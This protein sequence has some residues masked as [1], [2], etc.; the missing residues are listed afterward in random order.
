ME[1][2][3]PIDTGINQHKNVTDRR[4]AAEVLRK[5]VKGILD[6][7]FNPF[8]ENDSI[9][10]EENL[11]KMNAGDA[12]D[13]ALTIGKNLWAETSYPDLKS[14]V[15]QFK[16][17]LNDNG[18][19]NRYITAVTKKTVQRY[20]NTILA[21]SS[22][23]N[24]NNTK[25]TLSSAF[26][27]LVDNYIIPSNFIKEIKQLNS[28]PTRHRSYS[29]S[30]ETELYNYMLHND[31]LLLLYI[32]FVCYNFMRPVEVNRLRVKDLDIRDKTLIFQAK[33]K[34]LQTKYM[35]AILYKE[36]YELPLGEPED[37]IFTPT[38]IGKWDANE[39]SRREH[40]SKRFKLVKDVFGLGEDYGIYSFRHTFIT[41]LYNALITKRT[42]DDAMNHM[43]TITGHATQ[44]AL[45][46]YLRTTDTFKPEDWS[47][48]LE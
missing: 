47:E 15:T 29:Q 38:G 26:T 20:L 44:S 5:T 14:R 28:N 4:A 2:Q 45:K 11:E 6:A 42:P 40:F 35:P 19:K 10:D 23:S 31:R 22:A 46:K 41:K 3:T 43:L 32:K 8:L 13:Y 16:I 18:Y 48:Y 36:L 30:L 27:I 21:R 25:N 37:F 33:N 24:R 7:G 1:R 12:L 9:D 34:P 39:R 17:W